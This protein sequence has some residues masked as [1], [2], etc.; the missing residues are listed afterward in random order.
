MRFPEER[1]TC[2]RVD[3]V[4]PCVEDV[5]SSIAYSDPLER[6]LS[7]PLSKGDIE[8]IDSIV[9]MEAIDNV[10]ALEALKEVK[11]KPKIEELHK[12]IT[13]EKT[14]NPQA[15]T[16]DGLVL[17]QLPNHLRYAFLGEDST[18]PVIISSSLNQEEESKLITV[19]KRYSLAFAW[20]I[21]DI[22]GIIPAICMHK[23]LMEDSHKPSIEHQRRLN[24]IMKEVVRA[25][26]L[27]LLNAGIIY[28]IS[29]SSWVSPVQVVPK[30]GGM[31][32]VKNEKNE[33]IPRKQ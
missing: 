17:K 3:I 19:L 18:K 13:S 21:S 32:V 9:D 20:S 28:A 16:S 14:S 31:T 24:S 8:V 22:K 29:D 15:T 7:T 5:I 33:L 11:E 25:E 4:N 23:I 27:K 10:F 2:N 6:C 26:V 30:K 12:E 1:S